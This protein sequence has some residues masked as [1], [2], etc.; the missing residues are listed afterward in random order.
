MSDDQKTEVYTGES[1]HAPVKTKQDLPAPESAAE[2]M[3]CYVL[4][5]STAYVFRGGE[6]KVEITKDTA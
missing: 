5:N 1:W 4:E 3:M 2:G 6:W